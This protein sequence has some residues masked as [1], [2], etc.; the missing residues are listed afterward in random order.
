LAVCQSASFNL[1]PAAAASIRSQ[2]AGQLNSSASELLWEKD[3]ARSAQAP[4]PQEE[5]KARTKRDLRETTAVG[6]GGVP[7]IGDLDEIVV[8]WPEVSSFSVPVETFIAG[9]WIT[10]VA[11]LPA[12]VIKLEGKNITRTQ[13]VL[14]VVMWIIFFGGV[15][16]FTNVLYFQSAHFTSIRRLTIVEAV[17]FM[18]QILTTVGYGDITPAKP[19]GQVFVAFYV[20]FSLLIIAN[21]VTEVSAIV[22]ERSKKWAE[23]MLDDESQRRMRFTL[24]SGTR[25]MA[26]GGSVMTR[27]HSMNVP[28]STGANS[29]T[30]RQFLP[31]FV[32]G[33]QHAPELDFTDLVSATCTYAMFA[34]VGTLF[35]HFYPG[36]GKTVFQGIYMSVITLST[37]GFGAYT[38]VTDAGKVFAAFWMLF[39][40]ASLVGVV[41]AFS[42]L[43]EQMKMRERWKKKH[44]GEEVARFL[45]DAPEEMDRYEFVTRSLI[46]K[47]LVSEKDIE[48]IAR[49]FRVH[50]DN[51]TISR[52]TL[53]ERFSS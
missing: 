45:E 35:F 48:E 27:A 7:L 14:F 43:K 34:L 31:T 10:M 2:H 25:S 38:P 29:A 9:V 42:E 19:R 30:P 46:K 39:G 28:D 50:S 22:S 21:V 36:E 47:H 6:D 51:G 41:G 23:E 52:S 37:V 3:A 18:S 33:H 5:E 26:V 49:F 20:L 24:G 32:R 13:M 40:S 16:L 4:V 1:W 11:S 8:I 15:Y 44:P 12:I 53:E 17:Y